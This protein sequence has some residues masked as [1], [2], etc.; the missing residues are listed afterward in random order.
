MKLFDR[1]GYQ[2]EPETIPHEYVGSDWQGNHI[3]R[4]DYD[5]YFK[6]DNDFVLDEEKEVYKYVKECFEHYEDQEGGWFIIDGLNIIDDPREVYNHAYKYW[7][8]YYSTEI[9]EVN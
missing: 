7:N 2:I 4:D 1:N 5:E 3:F 9:D 8:I 6:Y